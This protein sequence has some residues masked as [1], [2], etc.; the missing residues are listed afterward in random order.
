MTAG[1][2]GFVAGLRRRLRIALVTALALL[3]GG[4]TPAPRR[5]ERAAG[6]PGSAGR[7]LA[8]AP[9]RDALP[10]FVLLFIGDGMGPAQV[11]AAERYHAAAASAERVRE[12]PLEFTRFGVQTMVGTGSADAAVTDSA[13]AATA[14]AT[15]QKTRNGHLGVATDGRTPLVSV[16]SLARDGG[17][18]IALISSAP[19]DHA[20]PA[21][22]YAHRASRG[23]LA[24]VAADLLACGYDYFGG[25]GLDAASAA[26]PAVSSVWAS[27]A[28][29]G[30]TLAHAP[31]WRDARRLPAFATAR[32]RDDPAAM[33]FELDR[34]P[35]APRLADFTRQALE[36]MGTDRGF[37]LLVEGGQIDWACHAGDL[38][39]A[40]AETLE[41]G[42]AVAVGIE[43]ASRH[44]GR[45]LLVVTADH[46]TGGLALGA[47]PPGGGF[48]A[49]RRQT[50]SHA[51]LAA[52][53]GDALSTRADATLGDLAPLLER[54]LG[55]PVVG[56]A[57]AELGAAFAAARQ[58]LGAGRPRS[59]LR[60]AAAPLVTAALARLT[61]RAGA[62]W[63]TTAHT[64]TPVRVYAEG[65][66]AARFAGLRDNAEVGRVLVDLVAAAVAADTVP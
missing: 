27:L 60:D 57:A 66:A 62:R 33:P 38:G 26:E 14:L 50:M 48:A 34:P 15:G 21:A 63:S 7:A 18:R 59:S 37:F 54:A 2:G 16:A 31:G 24:G 4:G 12:V 8:L 45:T 64:A 42:A 11:D 20:T 44:A 35:A 43:F 10:R 25:G 53:V 19:L 55:E 36:L 49:L 6:A 32:A 28:A 58:G 52:A 1:A 46:E 47:A 40:A 9:G 5:A 41:L 30:Y 17:W 22:F 39:A 13:A 65:T 56:E 61:R 51:A 3:G 23:D 29:R